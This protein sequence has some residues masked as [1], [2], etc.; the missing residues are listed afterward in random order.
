MKFNY[1]FKEWYQNLSKNALFIP[2][3]HE[4][5][6]SVFLTNAVNILHNI[7]K[8]GKGLDVSPFYQLLV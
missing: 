1:Y 5:I 8:A 2:G 6:V 3:L 4:E 7:K